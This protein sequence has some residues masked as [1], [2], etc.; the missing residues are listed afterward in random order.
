[1]L[2]IKLIRE[3]PELVRENLGRRH[4]KD[5]LKLLDRVLKTDE[6]WRE[7]T[8][9][10]N[11]LRSKRNA[12]SIEIA[13]LKKEGKLKDAELK[14]KEAARIPTRIRQLESKHEQLAEE[15][16]IGLMSLPNM[17]HE[18]VPFGKDDHDN[19]E[20]RRVGELPAFGFEPKDHV[21]IMMA[22]GLM[23]EERAA[24]VAGSETR[25]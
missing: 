1:M 24:K 2:D 10:V 19:V 9:K 11:D 12:I 16:R 22:L 7:L 6:K 14:V 25:A 18:S 13:A 17:L 4:D 15:L 21:Q 3:T 23:D 5:K 20:I 8:A